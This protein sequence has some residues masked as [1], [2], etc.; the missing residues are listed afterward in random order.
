MGHRTLAIF[1]LL[2]LIGCQAVPEH[3][4]LLEKQVEETEITSTQLGV[5]MYEFVGHSSDVVVEGADRI[6]EGTRDPE[7][8]RNALRW[9]INTI[10]NCYRAAARRDALVAFLDVW[11]FCEQLTSYLREGKGCA[12]FGPH[13][14]IAVEVALKLNAD[15]VAIAR[16]I[17]EDEERVAS[18][19]EQIREQA[20][21][22]PLDNLYFVR[23]SMD[24]FYLKQIQL[25][26]RSLTD[27][28]GSM[29]QD[30]QALQ[31]LMLIYMDNLPD[32]ARW[33]GEL[34]L[35]DA[36]PIPIDLNSIK[37]LEPLIACVERL[38]E[39]AEEAPALVQGES[40]T[41]LDAIHTERMESFEEIERMRIETMNDVERMRIDT[42]VGIE[43]LQRT[44]MDDIGEERKIV[45]EELKKE[46]VAVVEAIRV[47]RIAAFDE[48]YKL[49]DKTMKEI[50]AITDHKLQEVGKQ[51]E[52]M[53]DHLMW[54][55]T[56]FTGGLCVVLIVAFIAMR[57]LG[58]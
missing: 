35:I 11:F 47:E 15:I 34:L 24:S 43:G 39:V 29:T 3:K 53:I 46:R 40:K 19:Q 27:V 5:L 36:P 21:S 50:D 49:Q 33:H 23:P 51:G 57:K 20:E 26:S 32:L 55:L 4:G 18:V 30:I 54:R 41:A 42:M 13:Q 10:S 14:M 22:H 56:Q 45:L 9:K 52:G 44:T 1:L 28:V 31:S 38:T 58:I 7:V 2:L 17:T 16:E 6:M 8:Y 25:G 48:L 12:L 37:E